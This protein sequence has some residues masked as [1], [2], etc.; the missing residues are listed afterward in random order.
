MAYN[1]EELIPLDPNTMQPYNVDPGL[2]G[3][4]QPNFSFGSRFSNA[5]KNILGDRD[6][7]LALLQNSGYSQNKRSFGEILGTSLGQSQQAKSGRADDD[8]R[9][10]YM[11]AQIQNMG[12]N[13]APSSVQEYEYARKNGYTGSFQ[14]WTVAGG[15]SSRP[16]SVQEWEFYNKLPEAQ[17]RLYLEMKRNPNFKVQDVQGAPTV[18][19]GTP[20]G[21]V[22]TTPL[23]TTQQE[24]TAAGTIKQAES[25]GGALGAAQGGIQGEIQKK[26]SNSQTVTGLVGD[27]R[28]ILKGATGSLGGTAID[29]MAGAAGISTPGARA[30]A[31]LRVIQAG[32][33]T[34]MPRMEGPQ[35]DADVKLYQE[36]A[37]QVGDPTVPTE[38]RAAALDTI[39]EIQK[40]YAERAGGKK[41]VYD[42]ATG[43]FK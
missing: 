36:A 7:A 20:G 16:S 24:A 35:S 15:Q 43:T 19:T 25:A 6:L 12:G 32:L 41:L 31:K 17:K 39:E 11:Q 9:R 10:Q 29:R 33:M 18:V 8:L 13:R 42:P 34:N 23:S 22:Q 3:N 40:R 1:S 14:E 4:R 37:A 26:G 38:T 27:A 21:G 5:T 2:L 28:K 30:T